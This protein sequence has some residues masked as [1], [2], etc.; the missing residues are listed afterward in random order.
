MTELPADV[1]MFNLR[2]PPDLYQRV[3][4]LADLHGHSRHAEML[5]A[6]EHWVN[7]WRAMG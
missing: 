6:I 1:A 7:M 2:L 5:N 4:E 3:I